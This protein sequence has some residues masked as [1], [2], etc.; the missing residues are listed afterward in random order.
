M[1]ENEHVKQLSAARVRLIANRRSTAAE[2][3]D[4]SRRGL[5]GDTCDALIL[6]QTTIEAIDRALAD[7]AKLA[8]ERD[9]LPTGQS[10]G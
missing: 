7:E 2:I 1:A 4:E 8:R 3:A 9:A 6:I 10:S 5:N